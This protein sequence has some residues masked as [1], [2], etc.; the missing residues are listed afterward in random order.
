MHNGL[1]KRTRWAGHAASMGENFLHSLVRKIV[2][3]RPLRRPM[4]RWESNI[5]MDI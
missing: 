3:K 5:K 4:L 2:G 1:L